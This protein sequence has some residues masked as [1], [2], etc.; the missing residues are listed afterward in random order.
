MDR[1]VINGRA[2]ISKF[3]I[4]PFLFPGLWPNACSNLIFWNIDPT[5]SGRDLEPPSRPGKALKDSASLI[6]SFHL[7]AR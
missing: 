1:K 2:E 3:E 7:I 4:K 6:R 5:D